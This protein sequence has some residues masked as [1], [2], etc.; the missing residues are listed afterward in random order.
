MASRSSPQLYIEV[1]PKPTVPTVTNGIS[2]MAS[3]IGDCPA[4]LEPKSANGSVK[5]DET[6]T[7]IAAGP[8]IETNRP[9]E[10]TGSILRAGY[11][12]GET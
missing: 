6:S 9:S 10:A 4:R 1:A 12:V 2:A 3:H 8:A 11:R 7:P 5:A